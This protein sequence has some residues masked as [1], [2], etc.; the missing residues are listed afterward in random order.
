MIAVPEM[1]YQI[2]RVFGFFVISIGSSRKISFSKMGN[3]I[4]SISY[5]KYLNVGT[6]AIA[7]HQASLVNEPIRAIDDELQASMLIL[8]SAQTK[9]I[10]NAYVTTG[11]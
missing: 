4:R 3:Y 9:R 2:F 6:Y 1:R 10:K 5:Y 8:E 11:Q 7:E